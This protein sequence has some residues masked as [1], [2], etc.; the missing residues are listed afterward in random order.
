MPRH[1]TVQET[2]PCCARWFLSVLD[3]V[4]KCWTLDTAGFAGIRKRKAWLIWGKLKQRFPWEKCLIDQSSNWGLP[5]NSLWMSKFLFVFYCPLRHI[6]DPDFISLVESIGKHG[7]SINTLCPGCGKHRFW[8]SQVRLPQS[9]MELQ[10]CAK[11]S[12]P[13]NGQKL[14]KHNMLF[15]A[16]ENL[17][18]G[19]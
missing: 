14:Q 4:P 10:E 7:I 3:A 13:N 19:W 15:T 17:G 8:C 11:A 18:F 2:R 6:I 16:R 5:R 9:L 1:S 12:R